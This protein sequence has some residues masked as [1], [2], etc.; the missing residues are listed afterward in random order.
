MI[1][2]KFQFSNQFFINLTSI[3]GF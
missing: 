2:T 1:L 3:W